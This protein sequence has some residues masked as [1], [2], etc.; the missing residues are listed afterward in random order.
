M[1][2]DLKIPRRVM[3]TLKIKLSQDTLDL[4][5]DF[6][7]AAKEGEPDLDDD[8]IVETL[9]AQAINKDRGFKKWCKAK[10]QAAASGAPDAGTPPAD[11]EVD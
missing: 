6:I 5:Q 11:T 4:I 1:A 7:A 8:L 3:T 10:K 9:L 2:V